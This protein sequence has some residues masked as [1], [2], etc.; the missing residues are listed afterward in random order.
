MSILFNTR[1]QAFE[2][3]KNSEIENKRYELLHYKYLKGF[4][5]A[6]KSE[7]KHESGKYVYLDDIAMIK[8]MFPLPPWLLRPLKKLDIGYC[9][10]DSLRQSGL[11]DKTVIYL[12]GVGGF[13]DDNSIL[14]AQLLKLN[15]NV[16]RLTYHVDFSTEEVI[17]PS[18][19]T[20][21]EPFLKELE[22]KVIPVIVEELDEVMQRVVQEYKVLFE[23]KEILFVAHSLGAGI[24]ANYLSVQKVLTADRFINL[25]GT[26]FEP[27]IS[28]GLNVEQLHLSQEQNF[29]EEWLF[30]EVEDAH[31]Q[32][33]KDYG[34]RIDTMIKASDAKCSWLKIGGSNH[35]TFT[36]LPDLLK[37]N[38]WM[39][40]HVGDKEAAGRIR[41]YVTD[42]IKG[43]ELIA[44]ELLDKRIL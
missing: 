37:Y 33:G 34:R 40:R 25:D 19:A 5:I 16:I 9:P 24:A 15:C 6:V 1:I 41:N 35:L 2:E 27:A 36:D 13:G 17:Y 31:A 12:H 11:A 42:F 26:L 7:M 23:D 32:I 30:N 3:N 22:A 18:D 44:N 10:V 20:A 28:Q 8:D 21:M 4:D 39:S 14:H 43:K 38:K 29:S